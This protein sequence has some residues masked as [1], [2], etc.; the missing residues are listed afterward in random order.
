MREKASEAITLQDVA[1][2]VGISLKTLHNGFQKYRNDTP[3]N[4]LKNLRL[5]L[6]RKDLITAKLEK[7][8]ET[9]TEIAL[10]WGFIHLSHFS[11]SY[12][13]KFGEHP[14]VTLKV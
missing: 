1:N 2:N 8:N 12:F 6:V 7:T 11:E 10:R 4:Y 13:N 3:K 9:V 5:E 14:S